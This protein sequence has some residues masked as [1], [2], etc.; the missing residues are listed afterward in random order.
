[1]HGRSKSIISLELI[2]VNMLEGKRNVTDLKELFPTDALDPFADAFVFQGAF[3][4]L[5]EDL[6][7]GGHGVRPRGGSLGI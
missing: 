3:G 6:A 2:V 4:V 1:M 7:D 5:D